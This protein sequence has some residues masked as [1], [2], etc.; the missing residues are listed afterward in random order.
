MSCCA[1]VV[2][3]LLAIAVFAVVWSC[4]A[5]AADADRRSFTDGVM[6]LAS[7]HDPHDRAVEMLLV[8]RDG[9]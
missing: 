6:D 5:A 9:Q 7:H 1:L 2:R 8:D 3:S 4:L